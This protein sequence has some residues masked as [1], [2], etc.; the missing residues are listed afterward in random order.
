VKAVGEGKSPAEVQ[1]IVAASKIAPPPPPPLLEDPVKLNTEGSPVKGAASAKVTIVEFSDF[2]CPYCSIAVNKAYEVLKMYPNDVKLVFKHFP[3]SEMHPQAY[4]AAEASMAADA[5]GKF[6]P[7]HDRL[8]QNFRSLNKDRIF[9]LASEVGLDMQRFTADMSSGKYRPAVDRDLREAMQ[10]GLNATPTFFVNGR[11]Y[12]ANPE[13][14]NL[15][16]I[17]D[18]ELKK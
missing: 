8:F 9:A 7:M 18:A 6:W 1:K 17:I 11:K 14:Q 13:P 5:Q 10:L 2:Q 3:L 16:P 4:L 15:K 12:N